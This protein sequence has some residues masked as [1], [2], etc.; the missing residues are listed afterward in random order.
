MQM[1]VINP[2]FSHLF[3]RTAPCFIKPIDHLGLLN[4]WDAE[5]SSVSTPHAGRIQQLKQVKEEEGWERPKLHSHFVCAIE[6]QIT[7]LVI[8]TVS[9]YSTIIYRID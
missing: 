5:E 7:V 9:L 1:L 8:I 2:T 6:S 4:Q 3:G